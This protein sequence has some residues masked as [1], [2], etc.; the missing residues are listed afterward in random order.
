MKVVEASRNMRVEVVWEDLESSRKTNR[1]A[2]W[3][4]GNA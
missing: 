1:R 3:R 2:I 4:D